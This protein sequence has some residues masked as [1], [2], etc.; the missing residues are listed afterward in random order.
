MLILPVR[1]SESNV[2]EISAIP[3]STGMKISD[4]HFQLL[5]PIHW[6]TL[7]CQTIISDSGNAIDGLLYLAEMLE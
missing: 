1:K 3:V 7:K 2:A 4:L 5:F 6:G